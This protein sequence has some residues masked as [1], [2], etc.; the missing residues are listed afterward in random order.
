[1]Q[2]YC[3]HNK[4]WKKKIPDENGKVLVTRMARLK[5]HCRIRMQDWLA[6]GVRLASVAKAVLCSGGGEDGVE[7]TEG[8]RGVCGEDLVVLDV[9]LPQCFPVAAAFQ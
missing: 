7:E 3:E 2:A 1:M 5:Q 6:G 4:I 8:E 9:H